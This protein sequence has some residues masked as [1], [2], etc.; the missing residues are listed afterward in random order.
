MKKIFTLLFFLS[1]GLL[2]SNTLKTTETETVAC[3]TATIIYYGSPFCP[4]IS[5]PQP[6]TIT[7]TDNYTG[8]T[9][10]STPG[11]ALNSNTGAITPSMSTPGFY[12]VSYTIPPDGTCSG[13]IANINIRILDSPIASIASNQ[14][15]CYGSSATLSFAGT[16]NATITYTINGGANQNIILNSS[17]TA[18]LNTGSLTSN[19]VYNLVS[20]SSAT[21]CSSPISGS[22]TVTVNPRPTISG[23]SV[24]CEGTLIQL[25]GTGIPAAS[26]PWI[27]SN[28]SVA[29][30][31]PTGLVSAMSPGFTTITFTNNNG[32]AVTQSFT[33]NPIPTVTVNS[34]TICSGSSATVTATS[35]TSGIYDY[36]WTVP[37]GAP[38]PGNVASFTTSVAGTYSVI[39]SNAVT[40]C[41][42]MSA[43]GTVTI[44]P[45]P[46][47]TATATNQSIS[48]GDLTDISLS[49]NSAGATYQWT[50]TQNNVT[51]ATSGNGNT[52]N[53][54]LSLVNTALQGSVTYTITS[55]MSGGACSRN[56]TD[57]TI[58]VNPNLG[59]NDFNSQN[60]IVSP[61]PVTD[62]LNIKN[63]QTINKVTAFNQ[64]GQMV[65]Q[66]EYN[67]NEVQLDFSALKTGIYFISVD[68]DKKQS[69]F[70]IV[71]N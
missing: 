27:S 22:A 57:I 62:I 44:L 1:F 19:T 67:N 53:Q 28:T 61:N 71:K 63:N 36:A 10:T 32:C 4:N 26:N 38:N 47:I 58:M 56:V 16:P 14:T 39:I 25:L 41:A 30:V 43:S 7:G 70:K 51:G 42:S 40:V 31:N 13:L 17:G 48:S 5:T 12:T 55:S 21:G 9:F 54:Q 35:G 59:T 8:G 49:S 18:T 52:I 33:V 2:F 34:P 69:T 20:V 29:T 50:V 64:L 46:D 15:V 66:K 68:S 24:V 23:A 60:F 6:V 65:L 37:A 11:L 3:P 45:S